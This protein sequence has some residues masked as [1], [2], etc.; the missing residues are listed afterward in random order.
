MAHAYNFDLAKT[1]NGLVKYDLST[2]WF[3]M[4]GG[5]KP[6]MAEPFA[7]EMENLVRAEHGKPLR[8]YYGVEFNPYTRK[9]RGLGPNLFESQ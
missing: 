3:T 1:T 9:V 7:C 2:V 8:E 6:S 4:S 5:Q